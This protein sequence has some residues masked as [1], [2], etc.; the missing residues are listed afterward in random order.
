M[1][2]ILDGKE[3]T[4]EEIENLGLTAVTEENYESFTN[5]MIEGKLKEVKIIKN[6]P[7]DEELIKLTS[8]K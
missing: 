2:Y 3:L 1:K 4:K 6:N 7:T 8:L 5:Y